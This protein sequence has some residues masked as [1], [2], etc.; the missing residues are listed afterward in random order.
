MKLTYLNKN[1]LA[2]EHKMKVLDA[3]TLHE[4]IDQTLREIKDIQ[5]KLSEIQ[6]SVQGIISL[7]DHLKGKMGEGIRSFYRTIHEPFLIF[8]INP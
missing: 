5:S 2:K 4:G 6:R 3:A 1:S 7:E 8:C